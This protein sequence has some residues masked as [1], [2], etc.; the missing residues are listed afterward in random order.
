MKKY[1]YII[2]I[3]IVLILITGCSNETKEKEELEKEKRTM[4]YLM[5]EY[6]KANYKAN[7]KSLKE[8]FPKYYIEYPEEIKTQDYLDNIV[9]E[10]KEKY[11]DDYKLSFE[12]LR[13]Q[14]LWQLEEPAAVYRG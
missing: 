1:K 11:G 3:T 8:I 2:L 13:E 4:N 14:K 10:N 5:K 6:V 12:I 9:K 7:I